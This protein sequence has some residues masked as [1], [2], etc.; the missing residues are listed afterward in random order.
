M[1]LISIKQRLRIENKR[2]IYTSWNNDE[3]QIKIHLERKC[4]EIINK[5]CEI[6]IFENNGGL[7]HHLIVP[8]PKNGIIS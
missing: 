6:P 7:L 5:V 3:N 4:K 8:V 1:S 2:V